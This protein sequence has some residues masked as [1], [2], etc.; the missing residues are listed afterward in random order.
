MLPRSR[1]I[2]HIALV[3]WAIITIMILW[4]STV[5]VLRAMHK[6]PRHPHSWEKELV[7]PILQNY[8]EK[9]RI[10]VAANMAHYGGSPMKRSAQ[11]ALE[12]LAA[13]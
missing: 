4:H 3:V 9:M 5:K 11:N 1:R 2:A 8:L 6:E 7:E 13:G 12:A 10:Q